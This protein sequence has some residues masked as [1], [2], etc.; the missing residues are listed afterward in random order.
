[1]PVGDG[2]HSSKVGLFSQAQSSG[3]VLSLDVGWGVRNWPHFLP[4]RR[5]SLEAYT[6]FGIFRT[7]RAGIQPIIGDTVR[8]NIS[9]SQR[10]STRSFSSHLLQFTFAGFEAQQITKIE[11]MLTITARSL[12]KTGGCPSCSEETSRIQSSS[13]RHPQ[14]VPISGLQVQLIVRVRRFR[15]LNSQCARQTFAEHSPALPVSARQ[16]SRV[17]TML[18]SIAVVLS[19]QAGS[20]PAEQRAMLVSADTLLRRA[21]KKISMPPTPRVLGVDDV[22]FRRGH[23]YGTI[24]IDVE[25]HQPVDLLDVKRDKIARISCLFTAIM[26]GYPRDSFAT[27]RMT[28]GYPS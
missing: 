3:N 9:F 16:T 19:G 7:L 15:C 17:G 6:P 14:D 11:T 25:T 22:A 10:V 13:Q 4:S 26:S 27:S 5:C 18:E 1:M 8:E 2:V 28:S 23:T 12:T 24:L 21:K 20:R